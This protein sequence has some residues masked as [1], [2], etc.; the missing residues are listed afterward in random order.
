MVHYSSTEDFLDWVE[1]T[2]GLLRRSSVA[3]TTEAK[4]IISHTKSF[5]GLGEEE[6]LKKL[7]SNVKKEKNYV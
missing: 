1:K 6:K 3:S 2:R 4:D 5:R 7:Y